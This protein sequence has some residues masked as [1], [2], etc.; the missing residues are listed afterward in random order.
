MTIAGIRASQ[1]KTVPHAILS[2]DVLPIG[3]N[4]QKSRINTDATD[5]HGFF[6]PYLRTSV[7]SASICGCLLNRTRMGAGH[8]YVP[9]GSAPCIGARGE[10]VRCD[11]EQPVGQ[12]NGKRKGQPVVLAVWVGS[13]HGCPAV[14]C[15][16]HL[17]CLYQCE[18]PP[19]GEPVAVWPK[20]V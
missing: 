14:L 20:A 9:N 7:R 18:S 4:L 3:A 11:A 10:T 15:Y 6:F 1:L 5:G 8:R 19:R 2:Y 12:N 16:K 13:R 17:P